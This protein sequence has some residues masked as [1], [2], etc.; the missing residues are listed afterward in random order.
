[1]TNGW[2]QNIQRRVFPPCCLLCRGAAEND[3]LCRDCFEDLPRN[4]DACDFCAAP[5]A[6]GRCGRC[7]SQPAAWAR[8]WVP[9]AYRFPVDRLI[10]CFKYSGDQIAGRV[11]AGAVAAEASHRLEAGTIPPECLVPVPLH[12][13]RARERGF[14]QAVAVAGTIGHRLDLPVR[15]DLIERTRPT[16]TQAS[17]GAQERSRNLRGAFAPTGRPVSGHVALVDDVLTSGATAAAAAHALYRAG[18]SR[19]DVWCI[20]RGGSQR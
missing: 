8:A 13:S 9:F 16:R 4:A 11:L 1:M 17:L 3:D 12:P 10:G 5:A 6:A 14:D 20:A 15:A 19:V 7:L 18:A 2:L